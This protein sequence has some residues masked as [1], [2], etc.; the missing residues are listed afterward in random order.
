MALALTYLVML[1]LL[2]IAKWKWLVWVFDRVPAWVVM[3]LLVFG[4]GL[5][6]HNKNLVYVLE[7]TLGLVTALFYS[8]LSTILKQKT[9]PA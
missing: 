6:I 2:P 8:R 7:I 5:F 1:L 9:V 4:V 3:I